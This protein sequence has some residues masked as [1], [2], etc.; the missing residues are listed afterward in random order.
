MSKAVLLEVDNIITASVVTQFANLLKMR[1]LGYIP[2]L[3]VKDAPDLVD[4]I[5]SKA[6]TDQFIINFKTTYL[7]DKNK[8]EPEFVWVLE[9][10]F[11]DKVIKFSE[12]EENIKHLSKISKN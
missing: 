10:K 7:T 4:L 3:E 1:M 8:I 6:D 11:I 12:N 2:Y 5:K 9:Q